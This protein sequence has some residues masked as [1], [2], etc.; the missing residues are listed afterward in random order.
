MSPIPPIFPFD[1]GNFLKF[2]LKIGKALGSIFEP[3][4]KKETPEDVVERNRAFQSFCEE[5]N[6]EAK[7]V[8]AYVLQQIDEYIR[9]LDSINSSQ[10]YPFMQKYQINL[11]GALRQVELLKAQIPGIIG[12]EV[13]RRLSDTDME[14]MQ[15]RRMLPGAEKEFQMQTLLQ[16]IISNAL[17]KC[18]AT[19][20]SVIGQIRDDFIDELQGCLHTARQQY[21][22][23]ELEFEKI[24]NSEDNIDERARI[25]AEAAHKIRCCD[26][27]SE[28]M[29]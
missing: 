26:L 23:A 6:K 11:R 9:Y 21:E 1:G 8:E 5:V 19:T 7:Q 3:P 22:K 13:S 16:N 17:E 27:V 20:E 24:T 29:E 18:A 2:V 10:E 15:V 4:K 25:R 12:G 28:L 14:C